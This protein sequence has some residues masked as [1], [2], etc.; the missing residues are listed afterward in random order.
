M[1]H[2]HWL[3]V[4][5]DHDLIPLDPD[6]DEY[7]RLDATGELQI[8]TCRKDG[9]VIGYHFTLV[10]PHLHYKSTLHGFV[11]IY[12][13]AKDHRK[14]RIG[15]ELFIEAEKALAKRGV[16]KVFTATKTHLDM[17]RLFERL[18]WRPTEM[19]FTKILKDE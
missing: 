13:V 17:S 18:G 6:V 12:F 11:D 1:W 10:R 14:G 16:V 4:A 2:D 8:L 5:R 3:E 9:R 15:V 19:V 7:A